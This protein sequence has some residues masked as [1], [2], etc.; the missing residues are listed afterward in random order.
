LWSLE[1]L[2]Y[3]LHLLLLNRMTNRSMRRRT[4][5]ELLVVY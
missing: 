2:R 3:N 1:S 5:T 4:I